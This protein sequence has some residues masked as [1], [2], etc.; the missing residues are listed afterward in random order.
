MWPF[1]ALGKGLHKL[2]RS[3]SGSSTRLRP[4]TSVRCA[5]CAV[6]VWAVDSSKKSVNPVNAF[7]LAG[8]VKDAGLS[9]D[10]FRKLL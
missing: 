5:C 8:I 9:P 3:W 1:L 4:D 2:S 7:T 6:G 10:E